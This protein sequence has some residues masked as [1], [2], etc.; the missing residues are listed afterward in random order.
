MTP[1]RYFRRGVVVCACLI[2][3]A[4]ALG[5]GFWLLLPPVSFSASTTYLVMTRIASELEWGGAF[6]GCGGALFSIGLTMWLRLADERP[7]PVWLRVVTS[8]V[9]GS[10]LLLVMCIFYLAARESAG[11][12]I[13][14]VMFAGVFVVLLSALD[15]AGIVAKLTAW[16]RRVWGS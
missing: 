8:V 7:V 9:L 11:T 6:V 16:R 12:P 1:I 10:K 2:V 14:A 3:G 4:Q 5:F 13:F 15:E